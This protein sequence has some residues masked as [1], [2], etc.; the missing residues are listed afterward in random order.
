MVVIVVWVFLFFNF[1]SCY[2]VYIFFCVGYCIECCVV[3]EF[4][5]L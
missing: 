1:G 3:V 4:V 2:V 5:W